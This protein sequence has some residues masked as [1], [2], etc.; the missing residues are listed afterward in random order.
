[1][2]LER[3]AGVVHPEDVPLLDDMLDRAKRGVSDFAYEH[4]LLMPDGT[5][6][7]LHLIAHRSPNEHGR[8]EYIGA[9]QDVTH[10]RASEEALG[11]A[12]A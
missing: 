6:K 4:R 7:H 2:T 10:R 3:I 11:Q 12:R 1:V 5:V 9:V 8:L